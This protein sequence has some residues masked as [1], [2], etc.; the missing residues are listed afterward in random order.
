MNIFLCSTVRHLLFSLLKGLSTPEQKSYVLMITDQQNVDIADYD[1]ASLP[2]NVEVV[3]IN[4]GEI[5]KKLL[6]RKIGGL[7]K[8]LAGFNIKT[9]QGLQRYF[10]HLMF[11]SLIPIV[12]NGATLESAQLYLFND[13]NKLSRLLRLAF[14]KYSII[15]DGAA[16]YN[17]I[18]FKALEKCIALLKGGQQKKRYFGDDSRCESIYLLNENEAPKYIADKALPIS[19]IDSQLIKQYCLPFFK[20]PEL[21]NVQHILATQPIVINDFAKSGFYLTV[22]GEIVKFFQERG[23]SLVIKTHPREE[24][25][26]YK[27]A[28]EEFEFAGNKVPLELMIFSDRRKCNIISLYSSAGTGFEDYCH[29]ACLIKDNEHEMLKDI[30]NGWKE[31]PCSLKKLINERFA[32]L[33]E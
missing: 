8:V 30:I 20:A 1:L 11:T 31:N 4:R 28:F 18:K 3:F 29:R 33:C 10:K 21:N 24:I 26:K 27:D 16:N 9:S 15:E 17:G 12:E 6:N 13:R 14:D 19:F 32:Y 7:I 23:I 25:S 5:N 22:Y 2:T